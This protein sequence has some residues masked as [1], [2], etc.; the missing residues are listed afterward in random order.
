MITF[1]RIAEGD[2]LGA[3][4]VS[5]AKLYYIAKENDQQ[6]VFFKELMNYKRGYLFLKMFDLSEYVLITGKNSFCTKIHDF[7]LQPPVKKRGMSLKNKIGRKLEKHYYDHVMRKHNDWIKVDRL[8]NGICFDQNVL[9][10]C[11][12]KNYDISTGFGG[13]NEWGKYENEIRNMFQ[14]GEDIKEKGNCIWNKVVQTDKSTCS[15]HF[16]RT[17]YLLVASL[18]LSEQ[19][20][21]QAIHMFDTAN[22]CFV[23]FSDDIESVKELSCLKGL[24]VVY[25]PPNPAIIDMY[26]MSRCSNNIIA[27]STFSFWGAYLNKNQNKKVICPHDFIGNTDTANNYINGTWYPESFT[28]L[29]IV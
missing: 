28:A 25:M 4:M 27:N 6:I 9:R 29:D 26:L 2:Q 17:D 13:L 10:L 24:D 5:F 16:R 8:P 1:S 20:Y 7:L 23:V 21:E 18:N 3:Q 11:R 19:Y 14:F 15:I 12:D 22:T